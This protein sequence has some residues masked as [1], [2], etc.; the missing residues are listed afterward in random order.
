MEIN[1]IPDVFGNK[2]RVAVLA[3]LVTDEK[4]FRELKEITG[5]TD[6]NLGAQLIKLEE[7]AVV[8]SDKKFVNRKPQ[9]TYRLTDLGR[10]MFREYVEL[11]EKI[12]GGAGADM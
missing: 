7:C 9:T 11:L 2:L 8:A 10:K 5:A 4:T 3:A 6:G 1:N 12:I